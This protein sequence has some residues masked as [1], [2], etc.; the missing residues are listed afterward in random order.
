[1]MGYVVAQLGARMHY[2]VPRI[3]HESGQLEHF[4]TDICAS[5]GWPRW[6]S[7]VPAAWRSDALRRIAG[8]VPP[9]VPPEK[10]TAFNLL[11]L[12]YARRRRRARSSGDLRR[13]FLW[14]GRTF[15]QHVLA[16]GLGAARGVY[17]FNS[18]GLE[19]LDAAKRSM[20]RTILEQTI[21]PLQVES[22]LLRC[23]QERFP[24]WKGAMNE[25][26]ELARLCERERAEWQLADKILCG[27]AFVRDGIAACGGPAE[28]CII[29]PY[30]ID[31]RFRLPPRLAHDGPIKVLVVGA[32]GL[33][34][35]SPYALAAARK[36][37]FRAMFRMVGHLEC[38]E[39]A[40]RGLRELAEVT[41]PVPHSAML[42][43]FAWADVLLLPSLC[44]GSATVIYEALAASLPVICT[45]NCGGV[46]RNGVDGVVIPIRDSEAIVETVIDLARNP[47]RRREMAV[48]AG[49]RA[50]MFDLGAYGR[51]LAAALS[52]ETE[53]YQP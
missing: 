24:N 48:N 37:R 2:A 28:R 49:K 34:K 9:N 50:A 10:I 45:P 18:A 23:E 4:Y 35:G 41:G 15:C 46:V 6:C 39:Q 51:A 7:S 12:R 32:V 30:G 21:A 1:M 33:R 43:H 38:P 31:S 5:K 25:D 36:L 22:D 44:E 17:V 8:R 19:V 29:V 3:L 52:L 16:R 40:T 11:G 53:Q 26:S 13:A 47:E 20:R 27:S 14:M 42:E